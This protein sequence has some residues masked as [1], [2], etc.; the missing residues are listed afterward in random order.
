MSVL[1][2]FIV[3]LFVC[4][5]HTEVV[6]RV[7]TLKYFNNFVLI[8][9][10][11]SCNYSDKICYQF[12]F[13][14]QLCSPVT[15]NYYFQD[16]GDDVIPVNF[17]KAPQRSFQMINEGMKTMSASKS[18]MYIKVSSAQEKMIKIKNCVFP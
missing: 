1:S 17:P 11:K 3:C 4:L 10:L 5:F 16:P 12:S 6:Q 2:I 9:G 18:N 7:T 15:F 8:C 14:S 13:I